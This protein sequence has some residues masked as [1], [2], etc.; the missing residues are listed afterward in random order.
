MSSM[1]RTILYPDTA[2]GPPQPLLHSMWKTTNIRQRQTTHNFSFSFI[3]CKYIFNQKYTLEGVGGD[4]NVG[5]GTS[6][7]GINIHNQCSLKL[8]SDYVKIPFSAFSSEMLKSFYLLCTRDQHS[9]DSIKEPPICQVYLIHLINH[10]EC[11]NWASEKQKGP[12]TLQYPG[13]W[14]MHLFCQP[15]QLPK[16]IQRFS[17]VNQQ[18]KQISLL[19]S[20]NTTIF[21]EAE[22]LFWT[23]KSS[24]CR[25]MQSKKDLNFT[26][27]HPGYYCKQLAF[28]ITYLQELI[29]TISVR[30]LAQN[31]LFLPS[32]L[33]ADV[34]WSRI[35]YR[36]PD[37]EQSALL[38]PRK[39]CKLGWLH[40]NWWVRFLGN[41]I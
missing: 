9:S 15:F 39:T 3:T 12:Q 31:I 8:K 16:F 17:V 27:D 34:E 7:K 13:S 33:V 4:R 21:L 38:I 14:E 20:D 29:K 24:K 26:H 36:N 6:R 35:W 2:Q 23:Y 40:P 19:P 30:V 22:D 37:D 1:W 28:A 5:S 25:R 11:S 41:T 32:E 18:G 10:Y